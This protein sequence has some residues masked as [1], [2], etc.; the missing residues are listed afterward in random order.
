[1]RLTALR[2]CRI[3]GIRTPLVGI[4]RASESILRRGLDRPNE[5]LPMDLKEIIEFLHNTARSFGRGSP[6]P[7]SIC[8]WPDPCRAGLAW[9]ASAIRSKV[10]MTSLRWVAAPLRF[11][12]SGRQRRPPRCSR[13]MIAA[14]R[15]SID[16]GR[17]AAI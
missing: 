3:D 16:L 8:T 5:I 11:R 1:L 14:L 4:C 9:A 13:L 7:G 6:R 12:A 2:A 10:D 15:M 17:A